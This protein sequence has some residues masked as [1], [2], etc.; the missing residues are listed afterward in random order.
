MKDKLISKKK[1]KYLFILLH[2]MPQLRVVGDT[3]FF[4]FNN[5]NDI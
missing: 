4:A 1:V 2:Q 3:F 5:F